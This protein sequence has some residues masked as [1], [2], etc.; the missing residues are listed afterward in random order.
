MDKKL[1]RAHSAVCK[2]AEKE[3]IPADQVIRC[4]DDAIQE[5]YFTAQRENNQEILLRWREIPCKGNLPSALELVD[6]LAKKIKYS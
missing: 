1:N 3:G 4:I 5:A 6:Y 2:I